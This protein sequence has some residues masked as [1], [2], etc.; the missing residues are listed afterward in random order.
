VD[1]VEAVRER[2][3]ALIGHGEAG[4]AVGLLEAFIAGC[5]EKSDEID[6]SCGSFR[7]VG[8]CSASGSARVRRPAD[9]TETARA[10]LVDG[11]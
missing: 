9:P 2:V 6:D 10:P 7:V 3:V 1:G 8:T 5:F 4:R 11:P